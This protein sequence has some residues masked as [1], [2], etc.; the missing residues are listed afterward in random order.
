MIFGDDTVAVPQREDEISELLK[1]GTVVLCIGVG[2]I[3]WVKVLRVL[4]NEKIFCVYIS[5]I[6]GFKNTETLTNYCFCLIG[7]IHGW[8]QSMLIKMIE[9][10]G[11]TVAKS[12]K[13]A[14]HILRGYDI[15]P[16]ELDLAEE[17]NIPVMTEQE[18]L[19]LISG[20]VLFGTK[21]HTLAN[22]PPVQSFPSF[23]K[24]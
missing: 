21:T 14:S 9:H 1:E 2:R 19:S 11:G 7:E 23:T 12:P 18:F 15:N 3:G 10:L 22:G 16:R 13:Q 24:R 4:H 6:I 8:K 5:D 20:S 17:Q